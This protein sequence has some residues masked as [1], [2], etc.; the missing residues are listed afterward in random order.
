MKF[1]FLMENFDDLNC[2]FLSFSLATIVYILAMVTAINWY[3]VLTTL[4][5][6][7]EFALWSLR[8]KKTNA[9]LRKV[10]SVDHRLIDNTMYYL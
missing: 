9:E 5:S 3:C 10:L 6:C 1:C 7:E 4:T 2:Y 8:C